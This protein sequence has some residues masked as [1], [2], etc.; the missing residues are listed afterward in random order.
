MSERATAVWRT[1]A[2]FAGA[3]D[4]RYSEASGNK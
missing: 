1:K 4:G 2:L 3:E